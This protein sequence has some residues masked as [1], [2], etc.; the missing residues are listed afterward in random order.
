[1][2]TAATIWTTMMN[3][4]KGTRSSSGFTIIEV[5]LVLAI[6]AVVLGITY[7]ALSG[8][9][10]S[11]QILDDLRDSRV[12]ANS[13]L[14]R[15]TRELQL[16]ASRTPLL[17]P[18]ENLD[19][20]RSSRI[21]LIGEKRSMGQ[22]RSG[23]SITFLALEGGQYMP[24]G[25]TH[26]GL[27]QITYRVEED[28]EGD[29]FDDQLFYLIR[30]EV[31]YIRPYEDAYEQKMVFPITKRLRNLSFR[32]Y[33]INEGRWVDTWGEDPLDQ[34]PS[35]VQFYVEIASPQN[36]VERFVTTVPLRA[37]RRE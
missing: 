5:I 7:S 1:M 12:I 8:I 18:E 13:I 25:T 35:M 21:N 9:M 22:D 32:Y 19:E 27:V 31:P 33:D 24:D 17:P 4:K 23:D 26:S 15:M 2:M 20:I 6:L 16:A 3:L 36:R 11:K 34:L 30:E 14:N 37:A 28:P 29:S 10:R